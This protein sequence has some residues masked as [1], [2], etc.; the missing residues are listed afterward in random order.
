MSIARASF[1]NIL[2]PKIGRRYFSNDLE[3]I[4]FVGLGSMGSK[5]VQ[6]LSKEGKSI[7]VYDIS[8]SAVKKV[9]GINVQGGTI[10]QIANE[11]RTVISILPNDDILNSVANALLEKSRFPN[12]THISCSTVSPSTS[13]ALAVKHEGLKKKF[14]SAP[15]FARPD[16]IARKQ[17]VWM[18]SGNSAGRELA[19]SL[20]SGGGS[21][22]D[23]GDDAGA[24]NVVKLCGNFLI[25]SS[26][27]AIAE[28]MA[29]AEKNGVDRVQVIKLLS[30]TIFDCLIFKG[31]G[32]RVS[33]RDHRA[34]GFSLNLGLKDVTL[35]SK[36]AREAEVPMPILSAL[37]DRY[38]SAK[39][40]GR[41]ELDWSAIGLSAAEDAGIDISQDLERNL[42]ALE[43][44]NTY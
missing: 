37:L 14:I 36:A 6:N 19:A 22:V 2:F 44:G 38:T 1:T 16:G 11:C 41:G 31:Y 43:E 21:V 34:G 32:Q 17:A 42:K 23:Y 18:I 35:V 27:E 25:A 33:E 7:L 26:I 24:A 20:L 3:K 4:G 10:D 30:S 12:F 28:A 8:S 9:T 40:R 29:F 15:V 13:R 5:M 39:A